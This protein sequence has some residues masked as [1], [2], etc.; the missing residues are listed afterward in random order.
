MSELA[1]TPAREPGR[2]YQ[3][4]PFAEVDDSRG[5][6]LTEEREKYVEFR[7]ATMECIHD[8][9]FEVVQCARFI[10]AVT[11]VGYNQKALRRLGGFGPIQR[12]KRNGFASGIFV[13]PTPEILGAVDCTCWEEDS[14]VASLDFF[15][16]AMAVSGQIM[17][18]E[19][20]DGSALWTVNRSH[21][22]PWTWPTPK[23]AGLLEY[24]P[25]TPPIPPRPMD[26]LSKTEPWTG[27]TPPS[28]D[29]LM[30]RR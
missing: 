19:G 29:R 5:R 22:K 24:R 12:W 25:I 28:K 7:N 23:S 2:T 15:L 27:I 4:V 6:D 26:G 30:A 14:D 11:L 16:C 13:P 21:W 9:T 18:V 1:T 20:E 17:R 8:W 3:L 10:A